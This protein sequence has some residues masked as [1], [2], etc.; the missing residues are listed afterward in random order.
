VYVR[1]AYPSAQDENGKTAYFPGKRAAFRT[2][3]APLEAAP[4]GVFGGFKKNF[5]KVLTGSE[6]PV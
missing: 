1:G 5:K 4:D 6:S 2:L 3:A